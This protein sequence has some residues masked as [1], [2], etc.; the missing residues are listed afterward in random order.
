MPNHKI[1]KNGNKNRIGTAAVIGL[2]FALTSIWVYNHIAWSY[3]LAISHV[4]LEDEPWTA[5]GFSSI[6]F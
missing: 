2:F 5:I 3:L 1:K 6:D 4:H